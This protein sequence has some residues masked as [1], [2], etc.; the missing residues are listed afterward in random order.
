MSVLTIDDGGIPTFR[1]C[2]CEDSVNCNDDC[3]Y[4]DMSDTSYLAMLMRVKQSCPPLFS[5]LQKMAAAVAAKVMGLKDGREV[6][7][8]YLLRQPCT[9]T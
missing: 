7:L 1:Y 2:D 3:S 5:P 9:L 8:F 4:I 6:F